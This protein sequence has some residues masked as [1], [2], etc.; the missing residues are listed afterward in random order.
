MLAQAIAFNAAFAVFPLLM[1]AFAILGFIFG[2]SGEQYAMALLKDAAPGVRD[3]V[4]ANLQHIVQNR[5]ISSFIAVVALV[6]SGKNLFGTLAYALDRALGVP[7]SR[8]FLKDVLVSMVTLPVLALLI[9]VATAVPLALSFVAQYGGL[10]DAALGSQIIGYGMSVL[11]VFVVTWLLY[12]YL[13]NRRLPVGFGIPGALLT[14]TL[15]EVAQ[16]GFAVYTTH[17]DYTRVYGALG[18]LALL[19]IWFYYMG[20][21]FLF[22]AEF[23]AQWLVVREERAPA[24]EALEARRSA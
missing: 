6:W 12:D 14:T 4:L 7:Q 3:V 20:T 16:V 9:V 17:V 22:G 11:L 1:L 18:A 8:P 19:L 24:S 2:A 21:I 13:P 15:W 10:H 23:S 5:G